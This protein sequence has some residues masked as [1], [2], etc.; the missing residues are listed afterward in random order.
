MY[1]IQFL[2]FSGYTHGKVRT[3]EVSDTGK[4]AMFIHMLLHGL[5]GEPHPCGVHDHVVFKRHVGVRAAWTG[6]PNT[7]NPGKRYGR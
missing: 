6:G 2:K 3:D 4:S 7:F 1:Q 5:G